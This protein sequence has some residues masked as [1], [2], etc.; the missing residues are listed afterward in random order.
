MY[1]VLPKKS[2]FVVSVPYTTQVKVKKFGNNSAREI[3][4]MEVSEIERRRYFL[5]RGS[6][7]SADISLQSGLRA[8]AHKDK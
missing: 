7:K 2:F 8:G 3:A 4:N 1:F 6:L 5:L